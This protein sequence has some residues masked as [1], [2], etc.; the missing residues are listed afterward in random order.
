MDLRFVMFIG[1]LP[2]SEIG[3]QNELVEGVSNLLVHKLC[4]SAVQ[5]A[6][7]V[8]PLAPSNGDCATT[9]QVDPRSSPR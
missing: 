1:A 8:V 7:L 2:G 6:S 4:L 5:A 3:Q 9:V